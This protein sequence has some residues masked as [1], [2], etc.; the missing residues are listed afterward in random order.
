[1]NRTIKDILILIADNFQQQYTNVPLDWRHADFLAKLGVFWNLFS[2]T[3]S[4]NQGATLYKVD[5]N[6]YWQP[7]PDRQIPA[8]QSELDWIA[9]MNSKVAAMQESERATFNQSIQK[10][11]PL[12][13]GVADAAVFPDPS[14]SDATS[15]PNSYFRQVGKNFK[16]SGDEK[17]A[18]HI[19]SNGSPITFV[20]TTPL[21][22]DANGNSQYTAVAIFDVNDLRAPIGYTIRSSA[23]GEVLASGSQYT[24][25]E[26][27]TLSMDTPGGGQSVYDMATGK[28]AIVFNADGSGYIPNS[29][30]NTNTYFAAG[31]AQPNANGTWTV[32]PNDGTAPI[33]LFSDPVATTIPTPWGTET[34]FKDRTG[35]VTQTLTEQIDDDGNTLV[36]ITNAD[37]SGTIEC[38]AYGEETPLK[39]LR[40]QRN[41]A[42]GQGSIDGTEGTVKETIG[43]DEVVWGA[44]FSDWGAFGETDPMEDW[45][46][47]EDEGDY[48]PFGDVRDSI[49]YTAINSV[50]GQAVSEATAADYAAWLTEEDMGLGDS[51]ALLVSIQPMNANGLIGRVAIA[52]NDFEWRAA[53]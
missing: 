25:N 48:S 40:F 13:S 5:Q 19:D 49:K 33:G 15:N 47:G 45:A 23:S 30:D 9:Q 35:K 8:S 39:I 24:I 21:A 10:L 38:Y 6:G 20:E 27:N 22:P 43:D 29:I 44:S 32:T 12:T 28:L 26:N 41:D 7:H 31:A 37:G 17:L 53:A 42:N 46:N 1:M 36:I 14:N 51:V 52:A 18:E 34:V 50:N 2:Y 4:L 16:A 11:L 3:S